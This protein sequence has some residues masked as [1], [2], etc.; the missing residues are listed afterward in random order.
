MCSLVV[1]VCKM[2][3]FIADQGIMESATGSAAATG[4]AVMLDIEPEFS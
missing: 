1:Y 4:A 2:P 3:G